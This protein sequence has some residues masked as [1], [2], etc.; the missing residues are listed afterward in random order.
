M[1][2]QLGNRRVRLNDHQCQRLAVKAKKVGGRGLQEL[3]AVV[4]PE[5]PMASHSKLIVRKYDGSKRLGLDI[6]SPRAPDLL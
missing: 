2:E 3:K 6:P 5:T 4:T 1:R